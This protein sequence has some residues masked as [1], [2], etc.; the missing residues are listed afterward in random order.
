MSSFC[1]LPHTSSDDEAYDLSDDFGG[2][3]LLPRTPLGAVAPAVYGE[4]VSTKDNSDMNSP[5]C[6]ACMVNFFNADNDMQIS[7]HDCLAN[8]ERPLTLPKLTE[9]RKR[10]YSKQAFESTEQKYPNDVDQTHNLRC[11]H[12][13]HDDLDHGGITSPKFWRADELWDDEKHTHILK[14]T[15]LPSTDTE[16]EEYS[17]IVRRMFD[18]HNRYTEV[19]LTSHSR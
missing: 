1:S 2:V 7:M 19:R 15:R 4:E 9:N 13:H 14:E 18:W 11:C 10:T 12:T 5:D 6:K 3:S 8:R 17:F 16:K